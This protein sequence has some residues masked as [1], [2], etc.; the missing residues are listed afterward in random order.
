MIRQTKAT[1]LRELLSVAK[2]LRSAA[3]DPTN[4]ADMFLFM[5]TAM[6]LE[7]RAAGLAFGSPEL[8]SQLGTD[9]DVRAPVNLSC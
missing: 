6:A 4:K 8:I 7:E 9:L 5:R 3:S 2:Q 1:E